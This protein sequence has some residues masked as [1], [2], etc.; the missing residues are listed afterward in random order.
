MLCIRRGLAALGHPYK[1]LDERH[2][3]GV[4]VWGGRIGLFP[5]A[6]LD[7]GGLDGFSKCSQ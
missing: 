5:V 7:L 1:V 4:L 2:L 3:E 6:M